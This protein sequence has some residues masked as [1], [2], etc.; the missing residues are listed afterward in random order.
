[1][2]PD[3]WDWDNPI[4]VRTVGAPGAVIRVRFTRQEIAALDRIARDVDANPV[5]LVHQILREWIAKEGSSAFA[6]RAR[7]SARAPRAA[8]G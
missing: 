5:E 4:E 6:P 7:Q 3:N 8:T 2:D 1:M